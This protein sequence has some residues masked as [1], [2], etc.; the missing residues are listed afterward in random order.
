MTLLLS[1]ESGTPRAD[2]QPA[3]LVTLSPET[4]IKIYD[5]FIGHPEIKFRCQLVP[6]KKTYNSS[7]EEWEDDR[8]YETRAREASFTK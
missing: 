2:V 4:R 1:D 7:D 3:S 5:Y 8:D 6:E